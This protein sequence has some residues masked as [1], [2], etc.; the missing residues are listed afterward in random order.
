MDKN[1]SSPDK[2]NPKDNAREPETEGGTASTGEVEVDRGSEDPTGA[3]ARPEKSRG[4]AGEANATGNSDE[5]QN[6][7]DVIPGTDTAAGS[8]SAG[9]ENPPEAGDKGDSRDEGGG[10]A[11]SSNRVSSNV[12]AG[13]FGVL[14]W[15]VVLGVFGY[16]YFGL[17]DP[18]PDIVVTASPNFDSTGK[19]LQSWS[20]NGHVI[21]GDQFVPK[22]G[23]WAI[24]LDQRGNR[25]STSRIESNDMGYFSL[26]N[27]PN[28][29]T[30][31]P[32]QGIIEIEVHARGTVTQD[33]DEIQLNPEP[34]RVGVGSGQQYRV[35]NL[36]VKELIIIGLIFTLSVAVS[37]IPVPQGSKTTA[38]L[39]GKYLSSVFFA[40]LLT[41]FMVLYISLGLKHVNQ[42][43]SNVEN[44]I[45]SLGVASIYKGRYVNDVSE[46]WLISLTSPTFAEPLKPISSETEFVPGRSMQ[47]SDD[48]DGVG[49]V[50]SPVEVAAAAGGST[51]DE[52]ERGF[53]A[54]LWV[55]LV[56]VIG[57]ALFTISIILTGIKEAP[58]QLKPAEVRTRIQAVV[59]HQFY[60]LFAPIGAIFVYQLLVMAGAA[61]QT[62]S[63]A[64]V[65]LAAGIALSYILERA[66]TS[67]EGLI[68]DT[69]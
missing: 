62:V 53:G 66:R 36:P 59:L 9:S 44:E 4:D 43:A 29:L 32:N 64:I 58:L 42:T 30:G 16:N 54:P 10:E 40:F 13:I 47:D 26:A 57:S 14:F 7:T 23:V 39:V 52:L 48:A 3:E 15:V 20:V 34:A 12:S 24:A 49:P 61:S 65:A 5:T 50:S 68:S 60:I 2:D 37:L 31:R 1:S 22:M 55:L 21:Y 27:I 38:W 35:I 67:L 63:V 25:K 33:D 28:S 41:G 69:R 45:L 19:N 51:G 46:E 6:N 11:P 17:G 18:E 56:A 8:G